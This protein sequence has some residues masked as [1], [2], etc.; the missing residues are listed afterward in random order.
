MRSGR[1]GALTIVVLLVSAATVMA[2][3][4]ETGSIESP[5]GDPAPAATETALGQLAAFMAPGTWAELPTLNMVPTLFADGLGGSILDYAEDGAWDPVTQQFLFIGCDHPKDAN[6]DLAR[7][8]A[9]SAATNAWR[10]LPTPY[11]IPNSIMHGYDHNAIDPVDGVFYHREYSQRSVYRYDIAAGTWSQLPTVPTDVMGYAV[12]CMGLEYFP[13]LEGLIL[14]SSTSTG[15][16]DEAYLYSDITGQWSRIAEG[17]PIGTYNHFVEYNPVHRVVLFGGGTDDNR[18]LYSISATGVVTPHPDAPLPLG[19]QSAIVTVDPVGG[20]FLV[21]GKNGEFYSY[22]VLTDTWTA[23][24]GSVPIFSPV[25]GTELVWHTLATPVSTYGVVMFVKFYFEEP[26][27]QA[28]VYLY[29]HTA[30]PD[31][32]PPTDPTS[33]GAT[34]TGPSQIN[35]SWTASTDSGGSGLAGYRVERCQGAACTG[36]VEI[37]SPATNSFADTGLAEETTYR[38]RVRALDG[39]GN[40]SGYSNV[41]DATTP[42]PAAT[43]PPGVP[44]GVSGPA[45]TVSKNDTAGNSLTLSWDTGSCSGATDHHVVYGGGSQIPAASGGVFGIRGTICSSS[46]PYAWNSPP[47]TIDPSGLVWWIVVASDASSVEGS[48]GVD[49]TGAERNGPGPGGSSG[50]CGTLGKSLSN[51]CGH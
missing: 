30:V 26:T 46:P 19:V 42:A 31:T 14:A 36:F 3:A 48:W 33:L 9:Y 35:S 17:S 6:G 34:A 7:F 49:G 27:S 47:T 43:G 18:Q 20:D 51:A 41:A 4:S 12:C 8:V 10:I 25:R 28:W 40:S 38:Y 22:D 44:D 15:V 1:G 45:M 50:S 37:A 23:L 2:V 13:E 11:W 16:P 24:P 32:T 29:K 21:L 39:A 5:D